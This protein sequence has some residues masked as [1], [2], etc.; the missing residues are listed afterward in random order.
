ME[1]LRIRL[2]DVGS[3]RNQNLMNGL[4]VEKVL[5][6]AEWWLVNVKASYKFSI[7]IFE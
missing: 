1:Y 3:L 7:Y 6:E 2:G 5:F 4:I